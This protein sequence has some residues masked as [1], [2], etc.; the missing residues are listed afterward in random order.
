MYQITIF[1]SQY[2][3]KTHRKLK[4]DTWSEFTA[5][6]YNLSK[7]PKKGKKDAELISP[8][9]YKTGTTRANKNVLS[10]ASWAAI[11]VD[12]HVFEGNLENALAE[13][14]GSYDYVVYS[15][16]SS[17]DLHPKFRIVF[18]LETEVEEPRIRH[19]WY[20][21]NSELNS[22]GDA[23]TKDV[24]CMYYI[25]ADYTDANNFFFVNNGTPIDVDALTAKWPYNRERDSKNFLDRLP[26][27]LKDQVLSYRKEKLSNTNYTWT[28]YHD[29]P[30]W[31][32]NL[33]TEYL[34]IS[35]TGWYS[36]MYAI[37]VKI[38]GNA[39]YRGYPITAQEIAELCKQFDLETGNWYDNRPLEIEADR[40]LEYIYKNGVM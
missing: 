7:Q 40:A 12:D 29:C 9:I 21:L 24:S 15:T 6:L 34:T 2:D 14:F 38:A 27:E 23:Q 26:Q 31:P 35:S 8:A 32:K 10:W 16:A 17:T 3:N 28:S 37:M 18:N 20:A 22:I 13:T 39:T 5:L 11:D 33:A 30:F 25:P 4:L 1:K 19:F 36:K